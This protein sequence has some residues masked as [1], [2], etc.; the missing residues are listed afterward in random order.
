MTT[1]VDTSAFYALLSVDDADHDRA[2]TWLD[3]VAADTDEQLVTHN[4]VVAESIALIHRR[5]GA[6]VV[7]TF[8]DHLLPVC[9]V[10]FVDLQLHERAIAAYLAGLRRGSSFVDTTSFQLMRSENIGRAF[11][12]DRDF[13]AEGFGTVPSVD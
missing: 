6:A 3:T 13:T 8:V 10:R 5:L 11:A 4:Y 2:A 9:D 7:R 1:F 12:F